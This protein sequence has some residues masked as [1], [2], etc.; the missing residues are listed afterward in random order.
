MHI[1]VSTI[2]STF[3]IR[4]NDYSRLIENLNSKKTILFETNRDT[5][6]IFD[7]L[8]KIKYSRIVSNRGN[9]NAYDY[10]ISIQYLSA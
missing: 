10:T 3:K 2:S 1:S 6:Q 4:T 7:Y 9:P 8:P 5:N